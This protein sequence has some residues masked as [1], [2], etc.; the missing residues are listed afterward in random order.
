M[1]GIV[2]REFAPTKAGQKFI[3]VSPSE[4]SSQSLTLVQNWTAELKK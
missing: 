2:A 1:R 4:G 3:A